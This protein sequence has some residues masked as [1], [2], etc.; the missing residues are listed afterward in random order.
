MSF[1]LLLLSGKSN[2]LWTGMWMRWHINLFNLVPWA[3]PFLRFLFFF[4]LLFNE[5][6]WKKSSTGIEIKIQWCAQP[7]IKIYAI[8]VIQH[9]K[10]NGIWFNN[11]SLNPGRFLFRINIKSTYVIT[12]MIFNEMV[13]CPQIVTYSIDTLLHGKLHLSFAL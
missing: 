13:L 1:L 5:L 6:G 2:L 3:F 12:L 7:N 11:R 9:S 8:F 4:I 10:L